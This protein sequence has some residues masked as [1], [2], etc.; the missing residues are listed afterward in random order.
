LVFAL[1]AFAEIEDQFTAKDVVAI[2]FLDRFRY[3]N[4]TPNLARKQLTI[5]LQKACPI[6]FL[7]IVEK[8][9][10]S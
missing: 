8:W 5:D 2:S 10:L 7:T 4:A 1:S 9:K 6:S 3:G